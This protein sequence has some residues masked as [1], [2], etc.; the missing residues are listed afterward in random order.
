MTTT[1]HTGSGYLIDEG[2][3]IPVA[4]EITSDRTRQKITSEGIVRGVGPDDRINLLGK[5]MMLRLEGGKEI[6]VAFIGGDL[7]QSYSNLIINS[8]MPD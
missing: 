1:R 5:D 7:T 6:Q 8:P 2:R 4:Y 3:E